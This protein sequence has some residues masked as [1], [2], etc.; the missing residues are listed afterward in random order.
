MLFR[1][2]TK[3]KNPEKKRRI[4]ISTTYESKIVLISKA[5]PLSPAGFLEGGIYF[6]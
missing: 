4:I 1:R 6:V 2:K 5:E 3:I